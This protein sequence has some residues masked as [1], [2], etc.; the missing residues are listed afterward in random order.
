MKYKYFLKNLSIFTI[1]AFITKLILFLMLPFYT[2]L[3]TVNEYGIIDIISTTVQLAMPIFT[4]SITEAIIRFTLDNKD[5]AHYII[6]IA[7]KIFIKGYF[8]IML[9]SVLSCIILKINFVYILLFNLYY[10]FLTLSHI[11]VYYLK[12]LEKVKIIG[13]ASI[14]KV[15]FLVLLNCLFLIYFKIGIVGYYASAI[16]SEFINII[17]LII[18]K[19]KFCSLETTN[20]ID[21][22]LE[23]EMIDYSKHFVVNSISW[24]VNNASDK[25]VVLLFYGTGLTGIYSVSY[26]IPTIIEFVQ[27]IFSQAWQISAIKE[28][29]DKES[30]GFFSAMYNYYNLILIFVVYGILLFLK[31]IAHFLFAKDFYI[32]WKYVPFLLLAILF[33][34]LSGFLGTIYAANKDSKMYAKSTIIGAILNIILNF[35]LIPIFGAH[36]AAIA[37]FISYFVIWILRLSFMKKY[38][39]LNI[40]H[41][42]NSLSYLILIIMSIC[43]IFINSN[44]LL[45]LN[46]IFGFI[47]FAINFKSFSNVVWGIKKWKK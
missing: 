18:Y 40:N 38:V 4:L 26:K 45:L 42:I 14:I 29:K 1:S 17:I 44:M 28:Y 20:E 47:L 8:F 43:T 13:I 46:L 27:S 35:I 12:G 23:K 21:Y 11:Y 33:G 37:T 19:K 15:V 6:K 16:I 34:A 41:Y 24:W 30:V 31:L 22:S 3:L 39:V 25:Y 36:G 7:L 2:N 32:A 5:N 10:I 9:L